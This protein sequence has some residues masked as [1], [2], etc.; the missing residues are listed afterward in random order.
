VDP[1]RD[2]ESEETTSFAIRF[3]VVE[4]EGGNFLI[5]AKV[6][7]GRKLDVIFIGPFLNDGLF[8]YNN[9]Y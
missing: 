6:F 5:F 4:E 2:F 1:G 9:S 3:N 7:K 8:R